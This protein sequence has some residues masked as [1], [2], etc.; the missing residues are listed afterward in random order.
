MET[1]PAFH[2][3][4]ADGDKP[5]AFACFPYDRALVQRFRDAFPR[6]RW[7]EEEECWF[8]P[9]LTA[10]DR[11]DRWI[12]RELADL[13]RHA[14]DKGRDAFAFAPLESRYLEAGED[15]GVRTPYS[16][17]V[18]EIMRTIPWARWDPEGRLWRVPFRSYEPLRRRW[19]EIEEAARRNEPEVRKQ[20][21]R[22][23]KAADDGSAVRLQRALQAERRRRRCP[24]SPD[25]PPPLD[26]PVT[27]PLHGVVMIESS[28]GELAGRDTI[29]TFYPGLR[30]G[31]DY[32]WA[33]WRMPTL[34]EVNA[35]WPARQPEDPELV[36]RRGWRRPT[37]EELQHRRRTLRA[38]ER[39][40]R[41]LDAG[42]PAGGTD[43]A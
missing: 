17:T 4:P 43:S 41:S 37:R 8:V 13:D 27:V 23:L 18:V 31:A 33:R 24:G 6:A 15:L 16:R 39:A 2:V 12:A 30:E 36:A 19:P 9:G 5:G 42:R 11:L 14:D 22:E 21:Q 38:A 10:P 28:D 20:R 32:V 29:A 34:E 26:W 40:R 3:T 7:R 25:D 35:T 1:A